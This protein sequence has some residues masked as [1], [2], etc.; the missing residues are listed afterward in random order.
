[1]CS[2]FYLD[3]WTEREVCRLAQ[4]G[5]GKE[6]RRP[7]GV[8]GRRPAGILAPGDVRP[9]EPALVLL[10]GHS[11]LAAAPMRWGFLKR[12]KTG[13]LINARA[14]TVFDR[15]TFRDSARLRRCVIPAAG[16]YEWDREKQ[17]VSFSR[18]DSRILYMAGIYRKYGDEDRFVILTTAA[19]ESVSPVHDRMPLILEEPE[20]E[21]WIGDARAAED[22]LRMSRVCLNRSRQYE[23]QRL[24]FL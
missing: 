11:E 10:A 3:E 21:R 18:K 24:P 15:I 7:A 1:M 14:E 22:M 16:F 17:I 8:N 4:R 13:I 9:S 19:N 2:R 6:G 20:L 5:P 23:Q 12:E